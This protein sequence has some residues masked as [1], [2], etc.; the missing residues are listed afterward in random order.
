MIRWV[1]VIQEDFLKK[2]IFELSEKVNSRV[3]SESVRVDETSCDGQDPQL[4]R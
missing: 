3:K 2:M 1:V 4:K